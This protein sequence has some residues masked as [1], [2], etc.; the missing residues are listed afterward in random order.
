LAPSSSTFA[1]CLPLVGLGHCGATERP[2]RRLAWPRVTSFPCY[3]A[4]SRT[5]AAVIPS[6]FWA[7]PGAGF[8]ADQATRRGDSRTMGARPKH[9][10]EQQGRPSIGGNRHNSI[11]R[12]HRP[13]CG[14]ATCGHA[15]VATPHSPASRCALRRR[16]AA[17]RLRQVGCSTGRASGDDAGRG[18][19]LTTQTAGNP[20]GNRVARMDR[21]MLYQDQQRREPAKRARRDVAKVSPKW[22]EM[23][24]SR[25][26]GVSYLHK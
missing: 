1:D 7:S 21:P 5:A 2:R 10:I 14:A 6:K 8:E 16:P 4:S 9:E 24:L 18:V 13:G 19:A 23:G 15:S 25:Q 17:P 12:A 22:R 11:P 20:G 3:F 26:F